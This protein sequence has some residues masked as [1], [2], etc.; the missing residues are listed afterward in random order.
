[1]INDLDELE[2]MREELEDRFGT[3]PQ[4]LD[5][6]LGVLQIRILC[7]KLRITK[8]LVKHQNIL[9]TIDP[10]TPISSNKTLKLLDQTLTVISEYQLSLCRTQKGWR[11][12]LRL[13][14]Y[15]LGLLWESCDVF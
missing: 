15:Y 11:D 4:E 10:A 8:A 14:R 7:Q 2:A 5:K 6:L 13:L 1:M 3:I 9:L 12:D